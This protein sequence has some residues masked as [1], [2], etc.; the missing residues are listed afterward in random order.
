MS[1]KK[2]SAEGGISHVDE[3]KAG[4]SGGNFLSNIQA[5]YAKVDPS[6]YLCHVRGFA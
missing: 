4:P 2:Y 5:R 1:D 3:E 6:S